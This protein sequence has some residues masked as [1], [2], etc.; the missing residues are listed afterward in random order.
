MFTGNWGISLVTSRYMP[1]K[2]FIKITVPRTL[3]IL[4]LP[5]LIGIILGISLGKISMR[6]KRKWMEKSIQILTIIGLAIPIFSLCMFFQYVFGNIFPLFPTTGFK[7]STYPD[8]PLVTGFRI[9]DSLLSKQIYLLFD[10]IFHLILPWI[11]LTIGITSLTTLLVRLYLMNKSKSRSIVPNLFI[12]GI[13]F[14][15]IFTNLVFIEYIFK[16]DGMGQLYYVAIRNFDYCIIETILFLISI[17]FAALITLGNFIL[18]GYRAFKS[19]KIPSYSPINKKIY[20]SV[21]NDKQHDSHY[22]T[23]SKNE[24]PRYETQFEQFRK[25]FHNKLIS[26]FTIIGSAILLFFILISI[27]PHIL[28]PYTY[29]Q[30]NGV[31][32]GAWSPPSPLHPL[33]QAKSGHDILARIVYGARTSLLFVLGPLSIGIIGGLICGIAQGF[34][35]RRY[36]I[37]SHVSLIVFFIC[38]I[39][40]FMMLIY[41]IEAF[42]VPNTSTSYDHPFI[43]FNYGIL[44]IPFFTLLI[45]KTSLKTFDIMKKLIPYIPLLTGFILLFHSAMTFL[46]FY[47]PRII[48][49]GSDIGQVL[50]FIDY[51]PYAFFFPS[52]FLSLLSMGFFLLYIGLQQTPRVKRELKKLVS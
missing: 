24:E 37:S 4:S 17:A 45:V 23:S 1:V 31:F 22:E 6:K 8:P 26:P 52:L 12:I 15:I 30:A 50:D 47:D 19:K 14:S 29:E 33:G 9:I 32:P 35:N 7:T 11:L 49:L 5:L 21:I 28:T 41:I 27:F 36:K 2:E 44:L 13:S 39:A 16:F 3:D 51:A 40:L 48:S 38:P 18:I 25:Y 20:E 43:I 42:Y 34:L 46:G 10:Y